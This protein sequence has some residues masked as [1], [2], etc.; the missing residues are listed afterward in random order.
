MCEGVAFYGTMKGCF[1]S[2]RRAKTWYELYND[3]DKED[4]LRPTMLIRQ[5]HYARHGIYDPTLPDIPPP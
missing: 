2:D 5:R 4:I 3:G 1:V